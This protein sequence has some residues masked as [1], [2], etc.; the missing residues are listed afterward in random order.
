MYAT[1][2]HRS[3]LRPGRRLEGTGPTGSH[4]TQ[5]WGIA[6]RSG[7]CSVCI[8]VAP[9]GKSEMPMTG[10][11]VSAT[12][13]A[14]EKA[15]APPHTAIHV[16]SKSPVGDASAVALVRTQTLHLVAAKRPGKY[17]KSCNCFEESAFVPACAF[18]VCV[19]VCIYKYKYTVAWV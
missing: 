18:Y 10:G 6:S 2:T 4:V 12:H 5:Q 11:Q 7:K 15:H 9:E 8:G 3:C 14:L 13:G 1:P 16:A 19:H 17:G